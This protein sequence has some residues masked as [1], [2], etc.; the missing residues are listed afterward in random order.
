MSTLDDFF[1]KIDPQEVRSRWQAELAAVEAALAAN[2]WG[3]LKK[4]GYALTTYA[5]KSD[6]ADLVAGLVLNDKKLEALRADIEMSD[7]QIEAI[8]DR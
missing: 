3:T 1:A 6:Y 2:D 7:A 5:N 4:M 8:F